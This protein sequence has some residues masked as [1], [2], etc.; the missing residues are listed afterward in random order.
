MEFE[1]AVRG[2]EYRFSLLNNTSVLV[3]GQRGEYILYKNRTWRCADD[4]PREVVEEFGDVIE[5]HLQVSHPI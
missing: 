2:E 1:A 3:S 5:E 4:L